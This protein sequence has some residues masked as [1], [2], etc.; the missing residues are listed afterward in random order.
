MTVKDLITELL[1]KPM[2]AEIYLSTY[3]EQKGNDVSF[4]IT[5]IEKWIGG[6]VYIN[7]TDWRNDKDTPYGKG[8]KTCRHSDN[9]MADIKSGRCNACYYDGR[10]KGNCLWEGGT[11]HDD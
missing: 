9:G 1:D 10:L 2:D 7:F 5:D 8:C 6:F 4:D 11:Q 3:D